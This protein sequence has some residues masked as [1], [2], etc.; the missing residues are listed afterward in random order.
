VL[1]RRRR[2]EHR[3]ILNDNL[4]GGFEAFLLDACTNI[5]AATKRAADVCMSSPEAGGK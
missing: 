3:P 1:T 4:R 5:L 2:G